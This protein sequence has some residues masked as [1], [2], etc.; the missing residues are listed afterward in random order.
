MT[1]ALNHDVAEDFGRVLADATL[2]TIALSIIVHGLS[3]TP[4]MNR[5][6]IAS[7]K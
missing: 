5:H 4:L 7:P 6:T 2:A 1:F 3:A